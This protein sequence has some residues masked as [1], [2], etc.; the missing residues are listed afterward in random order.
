MQ[1]FICTFLLLF[2]SVMAQDSLHNF[3]ENRFALEPPTVEEKM[4]VTQVVQSFLTRVQVKDL[5][6]A[7]YVN[8]SK[9][10]QKI[11]SFENF[12]SFV[13]KLADVDLPGILDSDFVA[14]TDNAKHKASYLLIAKGKKKNQKFRIEFTLEKQDDDWKIMTVKIHESY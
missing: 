2:S 12:R 5:T 10:F 9:Q 6:H 14:F 1:K 3:F 13:Q 4:A 7:Y 11:T 8:T